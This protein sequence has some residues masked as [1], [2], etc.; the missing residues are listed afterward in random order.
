M[1]ADP[2]EQLTLLQ[3]TLWA[4]RTRSFGRSPEVTPCPYS[5]GELAVLEAE[6]RRVGYVPVEFATRSGRAL[7]GEIFP[8]MG[9]YS[10]DA[11]N[12]VENIVSASGWFDYESAIDAP[13]LG[14]DEASL[15]T[16]V[17]AEG[18]HLLSINQYIVAS[19]DSKYVTGHYLDERRTW[20]R[21][22]IRV[23]GRIVSVR[24]DGDEVAEGMGDET[25]VPG[26]LLTGY[27]L[28][29]DFRMPFLG[30]RS[31][32]VAASARDGVAAV[33]PPAASRGIHPSQAGI[34]HLDAEWQRQVDRLLTAGFHTELGIAAEDYVSSLPRFAPQP[35]EYRGRLDVPLLVDGRIPWQRQYELLGIAQSAFVAY[36]P[37]PVP[38]E[39]AAAHRDHPYTTWCNAWGQRF[40]QPTAPSD[41][42]AALA[43]DEVGANL[44]EGAMVVAA[45]PELI[46]TARFHDFVGYAFPAGDIG[47]DVPF[48]P[49][50][51]TPGVCRWRGKPEFAGNLYPLAFSVF[52]PL[53]RGR[54]VNVAP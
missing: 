32:G 9:C 12:E 44:I 22:G 35:D 31:F 6:Q 15:L 39:P 48:D 47:G 33:E 5:A 3:R 2:V 4:E 50:E 38:V 34:A 51:R 28:R 11:D 40:E 19:Q 52:R 30:G 41:A 16:A 43:D 17:A 36:F 10:L 42:R 23:T 14:S 26:S 25:P 13:F 8:L 45:Y 7:L 46:Q 37:P 54:A 27:D 21:I 1:T 20:A 18:R 29:S 53:I 24:F 49:I